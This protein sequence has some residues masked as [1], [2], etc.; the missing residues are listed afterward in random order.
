MGFLISKKSILPEE[1]IATAI[2]LMHKSLPHLETIHSTRALAFIIKGLYFYNKEFSSI[3]NILLIKRLANRIMQMYEHEATKEW[4]WFEGYLTYANSILPEAMLCASI[5][6]GNDRYKAIACE[7]FDFLLSVIFN[8]QGIQVISNK[9]RYKR[10]GEAGEFG[11]QP[12][13]VAYTIMTL[14]EFY[15]EFK[16]EAYLDKLKIAFN[17]FLGENRLNQII[18]NPCTGGCYDGLEKNNVNLNQGAESTISYLMARLTVE[19]YK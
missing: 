5:V 15:Q 14:N 19:K 8:D 7:S 10:G 1:M 2:S 17:W 3:E 9:S 16:E 12:I 6:T 4:E 18:Y 11:E 13:D